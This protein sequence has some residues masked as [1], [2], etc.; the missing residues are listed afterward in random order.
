MGSEIPERPFLA[1]SRRRAIAAIDCGFNRSMQHLDSQ[2]R[3][4]D[5]A[6][7]APDEDPVHRSRQ[8]FNVGALA[9]G[10]VAA[11]HRSPFRSL[12]YFDWWDESATQS[13]HLSDSA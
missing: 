1:A 13:G 4:E 10:R 5:V 11:H 2:C 12:P 7:E 9:T 6:H 8:G 3:E